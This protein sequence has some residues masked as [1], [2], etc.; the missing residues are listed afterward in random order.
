MRNE[1]KSWQLQNV[2]HFV[3]EGQNIQESLKQIFRILERKLKLSSNDSRHSNKKC[4]K[5]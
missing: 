2:Q 5:K 4:D 1:K 3:V